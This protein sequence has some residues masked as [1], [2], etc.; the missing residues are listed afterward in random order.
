[1]PLRFD[2]VRALVSAF[3]TASDDIGTKDSEDTSVAFVE[4]MLSKGKWGEALSYCAY[5]LPRWDAVR[6]GYETLKQLRPSPPPTEQATM[7]I[8]EEW[9]RAPEEGTRRQA[10]QHAQTADVEEPTTLIAY[11]VGWSG[12]SIVPPE[13]GNVPAQ[14]HQTA[15]A[16]RAALLIAMAYAR[17]PDPGAILRPAAERA[18]KIAAGDN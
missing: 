5:L 2:T 16:V 18:L 14:P 17:N 6:W 13:N 8:V 7:R 1:M 10:L 9:L 11:A 12:G 4:A 3:P 15:R